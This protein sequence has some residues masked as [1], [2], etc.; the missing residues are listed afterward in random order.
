MF[1]NSTLNEQLRSGAVPRCFKHVVSNENPIPVFILDDHSY[2][3]LPYLMKEC[4]NGGSNAQEQYSG[5]K[6]CIARN[7]IECAFGLL[8]ARFSAL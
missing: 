5:Y 6:L 8:K 1:I 7:V 2:P 4:A 3:L